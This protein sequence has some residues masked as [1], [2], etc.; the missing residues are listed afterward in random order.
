[1]VCISLYRP[2][3]DN[4]WAGK[5]LLVSRGLGRGDTNNEVGVVSNTS[6]RRDGDKEKFSFYERHFFLVV[7]IKYLHYLEFVNL[8][9]I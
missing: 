5:P 9:L 6:C 8:F 4:W 7:L 2:E 3:V 1:M